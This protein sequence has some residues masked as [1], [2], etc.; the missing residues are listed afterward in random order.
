MTVTSGA[1]G[2]N[3][4]GRI[5][6]ITRRGWPGRRRFMTTRPSLIAGL[7]RNDREVAF[8][9]LCDTYSLPLVAAIRARTGCQPADAEDAVQGF[10]L[11][12]MRPGFFA[13][14][15]PSLGKFRSWLSKA[16]CRFALRR[17]KASSAAVDVEPR[18][19]ESILDRPR[20]EEVADIDHAVD[21]AQIGAVCERALQRL[22]SRY[23]AADQAELFR[24]V[25]EAVMGERRMTDDAS[26]AQLLD[27]SVGGLKQER[28]RE[29]TAWTLAY[30]ACVREELAALGFKRIDMTRILKEMLDVFE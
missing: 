5:V 1:F 16:A 12:A 8:P 10:L 4:G 20:R 28:V 14:F 27:R 11:V 24:E 25:Y 19:I 26:R 30:H 2:E 18:I 29:K 7:R 15:D 21:R 23:A 9:A 17:S 13:T 22:R 3:G 6:A